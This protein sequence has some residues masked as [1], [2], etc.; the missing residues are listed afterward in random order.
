MDS[1]H[2]GEIQRWTEHAKSL[3]SLLEQFQEPALQ[4]V[5]K[6]LDAVKSTYVEPFMCERTLVVQKTHLKN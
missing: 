5:L 3:G 1:G 2:L 6:I 4:D